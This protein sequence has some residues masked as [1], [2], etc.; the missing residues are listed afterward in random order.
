MTDD[1]DPHPVLT[2]KIAALRSSD[3]ALYT[4]ITERDPITDQPIEAA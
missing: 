2:A 3:P 1:T 4:A